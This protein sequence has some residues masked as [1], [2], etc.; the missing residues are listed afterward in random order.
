VDDVVQ[1]PGWADHRTDP[2][3]GLFPLAVE[4]YLNA[5]VAIN[6]PGVTTV[7]TT[8]RYYALHALIADEARR[9]DLDAG[10]ARE[11]LRRVEVVYALT[12]MA[13]RGQD[14]HDASWPAPHGED[15]LRAALGSGPINLAVATGRDKGRYSNA[16]WG[17]L[18]AY[19]GAEMT[20][21][22][23][24]TAGFAPG[25]AFDASTVRN[26]LGEIVTL[27]QTAEHV[28]LEDVAHLGSACLCQAHVST[29]GEWLARQFAGRPGDSDTVASVLG[30]TMQMIAAAVT[31]TEVRDLNDLGSF[32]MYD[33][34]MLDHP[35]ARTGE[36]W[37]RWRGLRQRAESVEAWR[38][39][40][41]HMCDHLPEQGA[42][43][44]DQLG[45]AL[46]DQLPA[47]SVRHYLAGLPPVADATGAPLPAE[48][49][50]S[51]ADRDEVD[52]CIATL[53]LGAERHAVLAPNTPERLGF[54]GPPGHRLTVEELS[55]HWVASTIERWADHS[56]QDLAV[57]LANV[58]V[59]RAHRV[60]M[61]KSYFRRSDL[62]YVMPVRIVLQDGVVFRVYDE[63]PRPP[64]LRWAPLLSMGRQTGLF[65]RNGDGRWELGARGSFLD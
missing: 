35:H 11:L 53:M 36:V 28:S 58:M 42:M 60:T 25:P 61:K 1:G 64:S 26:E 57:H 65:A 55:P 17:F 31:T 3:L 49:A 7:T 45:A 13:H 50:S 22:I 16:S 52:R 23:L 5:A 9:R 37:R 63:T 19:R 33:P 12:C 21:A 41:T 40:W 6:A 43:T 20:L 18:G 44:P 10:D 39:L 34:T 32:V 14:G 54:E 46:A 38:Y 2:I 24:D 27:A 62:R 59:N 29:D 15:R 51:V 8:A 30:Q 47:Q 48:S 4:Q 56:M